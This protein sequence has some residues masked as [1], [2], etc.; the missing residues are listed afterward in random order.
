MVR[1]GLR[2]PNF[3]SFMIE[4]NVL[5]KNRALIDDIAAEGRAVLIGT[6][7]AQ[8][9][10]TN[11]VFALNHLRNVW[12]LLSHHR[13][14]LAAAFRCRSLSR[15]PSMSGP[16]AALAYVLRHPKS[17]PRSSARA[18][19]ADFEQNVAAAALALPADVA[20]RIERL[21][22]ALGP[23]RVAPR[24]LSSPCAWGTS[25]SFDR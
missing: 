11:S 19:L 25:R 15:I 3:D 23:R 22:D 12:A 2:L 10:F 17:P 13:R 7:I 1:A 24:Y 9:L 6:P 5:K 4:Y 16:Q 14:E 21:S 8:A 20:A 18:Q